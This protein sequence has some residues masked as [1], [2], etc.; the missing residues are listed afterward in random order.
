M[1]TVWA[2]T[3]S[4]LSSRRGRIRQ[5][6]SPQAEHEVAGGPV[7]VVVGPVLAPKAQADTAA[8]SYKPKPL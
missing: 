8:R 7:N 5:D 3:G 4:A 1:E 6:F 2:D